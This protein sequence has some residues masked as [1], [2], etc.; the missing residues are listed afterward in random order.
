MSNWLKSGTK[1]MIIIILILL[2]E[3]GSPQCV[4]ECCASEADCTPRF[5]STCATCASGYVAST[6]NKKCCLGSCTCPIAN[7]DTSD[8]LNCPNTGTKNLVCNA[9][10]APHVL[11]SLNTFCCLD[12][13]CGTCTLD[14]CDTCV[15]SSPHN[16]CSACSTGYTQSDDKTL[17]YPTGTTC[18]IIGCTTCVWGTPNTC[19]GSCT[20]YFLT[21]KNGVCL[22]SYCL[23]W[24]D[25]TVT[26]QVKC[27]KCQ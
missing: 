16:L 12:G 14:H 11:N 23:L 26:N 27:K 13:P 24:E 7:C 18:T 25:F 6:D 3:R 21:L 20:N 8:S 2:C 5:P 9:C 19:T 1:Q 10:N 4:M 22:D 15:I 17:C